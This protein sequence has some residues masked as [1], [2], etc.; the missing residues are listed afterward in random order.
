MKP[1][2]LTSKDVSY[3]RVHKGVAENTEEDLFFVLPQSARRSR[4]EHR[5]IF[6]FCFFETQK[7]Q[8]FIPA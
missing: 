1:A 8:F 2:S 7:K 5:G 3:R 4:K 6:Y